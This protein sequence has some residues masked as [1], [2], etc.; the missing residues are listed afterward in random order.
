M[1]HKPRGHAV[2]I[3][4]QEFAMPELYPFREGAD[5]DADNLEKLFSQLDFQ[6]LLLIVEKNDKGILLKG[7]KTYKHDKKEHTEADD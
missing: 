5:V 1:N 3:N 6:V 4:N 7:F 2:I